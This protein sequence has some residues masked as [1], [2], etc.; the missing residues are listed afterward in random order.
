MNELEKSEGYYFPVDS[1]HKMIKYGLKIV[2]NNYSSLVDIAIVALY[3][4]VRSILKKA[5]MEQYRSIDS[6]VGSISCVALSLDGD[7]S[8][9]YFTWRQFPAPF[10][11]RPI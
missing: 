4:V 3:L 2:V 11:A 5:R 1:I 10:K 9:Q 6:K 7:T 8:V